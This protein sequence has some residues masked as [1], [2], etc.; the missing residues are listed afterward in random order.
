MKTITTRL[1]E[2]EIHDL[3][4]LANELGFSRS[5]ILRK[6]IKVGLHEEL[7]DL[8]LELYHKRKIT[9]WRA[10]EIAKKSL[11]AMIDEARRRRIL[12]P[13][14][15]KEFKKDLQTLERLDQ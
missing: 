7:L 1:N 6:I 3:D 14:S 2:K 4:W 9:I 12:H 11:S 8:A 10:A 15:I 5:E 13:Y